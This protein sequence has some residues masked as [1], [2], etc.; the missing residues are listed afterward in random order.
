MPAEY[1]FGNNSTADLLA[2]A[3][4]V[5]DGEIA[6]R[7]GNYDQAVT[8]LREAMKI[9]DTLKYDE[10]PDW[11]QPVRHTLGAVL[12]RANRPK[13]A[14][15]VYLEDLQRYPENGWALFG[16]SEMLRAQGRKAEAAVVKRRFE[17]A[18]AAADVKIDSTCYCQPGIALR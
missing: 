4:H 14:E 8:N 10:P 7:A 9:E 11:I 12:L 18:W 6:A 15:I 5:L 16:L 1:H 17:R 3:T 13:E 2:I